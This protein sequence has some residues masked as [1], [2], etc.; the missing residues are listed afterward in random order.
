MN[1]INKLLPSTAILCNPG[2]A[3]KRK[4]N[5]ITTV[6]S[7]YCT[8]QRAAEQILYQCHLAGKEATRST[9]LSLGT[10]SINIANANSRAPGQSPAG[11][12]LKLAAQPLARWDTCHAHYHL[13]Q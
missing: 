11:R 4:A 10:C 12:Y 13:K 2:V 1:H 9:L 7:Q 6:Q 5:D 8:G 3:F